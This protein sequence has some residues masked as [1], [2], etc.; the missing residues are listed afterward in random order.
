ME[1][2]EWIAKAS[3]DDFSEDDVGHAKG[4][5]LKTIVGIMAGSQEPIGKKIT[6]FLSGSGAPAEVV[7]VGSGFKTSVE[8]AA[9]AHGI[10]AHGS[11]L[12]DDSMPITIGDYWIYPTIFSL[13]EKLKSSGKEMVEAAIVSWEAGQRT[14]NV[15]QGK[16]SGLMPTFFG[17]I[18]AGVAAAKLL[19]LD[20]EKTADA[21]SIAASHSSGLLGQTG[22]DAH[23]IESGHTC[24]SGL[25]AALLAK[26]GLTGKHDILESR[27]GLYAEFKR[28]KEVA[29]VELITDG[30]GKPPYYIENAVIKKYPCCIVTHVAIDALRMLKDENDLRNE[31]VEE[32]EAEVMKMGR[33]ICDRPVP[34]N[35]GDA[36]FSYQYTLAEVML[37][38]NVDLS[39]FATEDR[40]L[41]QT[42][43]EAELK[44]KVSAPPEFPANYEGAR[45]TVT[46][47]NGEKL[48][49]QMEGCIGN[50]KYYP[51][52]LEQIRD[53]SRPYLDAML[54]ES[55]R[56]Q[57]EEVMLNLE[58]QQ[59]IV[60]M[61]D[62]LT[63]LKSRSLV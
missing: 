54:E 18:A 39:S 6:R 33:V 24:R 38:G 2:A 37:R 15:G 19:K 13:A 56:N 58:K 12:E 25:L 50:P 40:L 5:L 17:V 8:N 7:L 14:C 63:L 31:D 29:P 36:R 44:V 21:L 62:M 42:H 4:L 20:P 28:R 16:L 53:V 10:F 51:M 3:Y 41:D 35:L 1:L 49:K 23:F 32:I 9:F 22:S 48:V 46:K 43:K 55:Q 45:I 11:E 61:M 34:D 47:K 52:S 59:D 30:L 27:D 60:G 57:V 26:E